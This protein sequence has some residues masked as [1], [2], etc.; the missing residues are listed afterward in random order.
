[1]TLCFIF[2]A[3]GIFSESVAAGSSLAME[4]CRHQFQWDRWNCPK[5]S[6]ALFNENALPNCK[7]LIKS[8]LRVKFKFGLDFTTRSSW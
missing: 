2:Q 7:Y 6:I 1:M 5:S 8:L 4:E 3:F